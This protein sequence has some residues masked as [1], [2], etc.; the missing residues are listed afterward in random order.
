MEVRK[1]S[2]IQTTSTSLAYEGGGTNSAQ[3]HRSYLSMYAEAPNQEITLEDFEIY[4]FNR[5]KGL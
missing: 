3:D 1:K 4:S 5:L 2:G